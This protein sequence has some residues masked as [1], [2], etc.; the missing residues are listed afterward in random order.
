[1]MVISGLCPHAGHFQSNSAPLASQDRKY[2]NAN[3]K[4][5]APYPPSPGRETSTTATARIA[6]VIN[7]DTPRRPTLLTHRGGDQAREVQMTRVTPQPRM[8][9]G[10][11]GAE[12][13]RAE[14][15]V[16]RDIRARRVW[17]LEGEG[18][19]RI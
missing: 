11:R 15:S 10:Q 4:A 6:G 17:P 14:D 18:T 16:I 13:H 5:T 3:T 12:R 19:P 9:E 2:M 7:P 1:M 8:R